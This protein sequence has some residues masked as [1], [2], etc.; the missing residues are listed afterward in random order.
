MRSVSTSSGRTN[1]GET[2]RMARNVRI[3]RPDATSSTTASATC[4]T[5]SVLRARCRSRPSL[6]P[7]PFSFR[8]L[9]SCGRAYF[10]TGMTP[11]SSPATSEMRQREEQHDR[12]ERDLAADEAG[13]PAAGR[14]AAGCR[15]TRDPRPTTPPIRPSKHRFGEQLARDAARCPRR[16]PCVPPAP[17]AGLPRARGT[18][19][20]RSRTRRAGRCRPCP[21]ASRA[22]GPMS[23]TTST[24]SGRTSGPSFVSRRTSR[25]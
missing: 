6:E 14:P 10:R 21:A 19:W 4:A 20:R 2:S 13:A 11:N 23:P 22:C 1:P 18:D 12:I 17:A 3:I 7:R 8:A 15:R 9:A 5:T 24:S 25:A 16:A